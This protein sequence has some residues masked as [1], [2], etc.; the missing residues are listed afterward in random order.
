MT[1]DNKQDCSMPFDAGLPVDEVRETWNPENFPIEL[2]PLAEIVFTA[3]DEE[4]LEAGPFV[5]PW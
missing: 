2:R 1:H 3:P 5:S 4:V